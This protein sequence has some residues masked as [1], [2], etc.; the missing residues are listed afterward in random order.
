MIRPGATV[1]TPYLF[2]YGTLMRSAAG[3]KLGVAERARLDTSG[4]WLGS[5]TAQGR[6]YDLGIYPGLVITDRKNRSVRG[7]I[8]W[9]RAPHLALR[10]LDAYEGIP[11]GAAQGP[12]YTRDQQPVRFARGQ[13]LLAWLYNYTGSLENARLVASGQWLP[14]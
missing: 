5:A 2:V 13:T 4:E 9:L 10:W 1:A 8:Y 7:E 14:R 11:I 6:L 12:E 3:A